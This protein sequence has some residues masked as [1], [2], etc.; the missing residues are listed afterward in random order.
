MSENVTRIRDY[1]GDV[2]QRITALETQMVNIANNVEKI[3]GRVDFHYQTLHSR[4]SDMRDEIRAEID[5][6]HEKLI[7]KLDE[8]AKKE[9]EENKSMSSKI[10]GLEKWRWMLMGG[11]VVVGYII[12]HIKLDKLL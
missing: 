12:A 10:S 2:R 11:A 1:S 7:E 6:K 5:I 4:I 9:S 8:H 3:E